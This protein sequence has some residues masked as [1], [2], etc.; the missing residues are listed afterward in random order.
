MPRGSDHAATLPK[1]PI[2]FV[3]SEEEKKPAGRNWYNGFFHLLAERGSATASSARD[4]CFKAT[5]GAVQLKSLHKQAAEFFERTAHLFFGALDQ[6]SERGN[7]KHLPITRA[8]VWARA[9]TSS[10]QT[11]NGVLAPARQ[12]SPRRA[13]ER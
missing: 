11:A 9:G 13:G 5:R 7:V 4:R 1:R 6:V 3:S 12:R 2:G 8:Q 10:G